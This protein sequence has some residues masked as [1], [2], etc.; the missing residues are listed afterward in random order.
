M[1]RPRRADGHRP[2][3]RPSRAGGSPTR[4]ELD[5]EGFAGDRAPAA[6]RRATRPTSSRPGG[7]TW[8]G[9]SRC[10]G[11]RGASDGRSP[12]PSRWAPGCRRARRWSWPW[13]G[14]RRPGLA[15]PAG[16]GLPGGGAARVGGAVRRDG[17]ARLGR[18]GGG[19]RPAHRLR[20]PRRRGGGPARGRR[21]GGG[22]LRG[23]PGAGHRAYAER[24]RQLEA[25]EQEIGPLRQATAADVERITDA[26]NRRRA[27][28]V[29]S[30]NE[31]VLRLRG[32][33]PGRRP[34]RC[35]RAHGRRPRQLP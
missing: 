28:H 31:R 22:A 16:P 30:E 13:P 34:R 10:C 35:R 11:P 20:H 33:G 8:P 3:A 6:R 24:R 1:R 2:G 29:V 7:A 23:A 27:R 25:A 15:P 4:C 17:P 21:R 18:G 26:T 32:L 5:S 9:S 19:P 14:G 12:P